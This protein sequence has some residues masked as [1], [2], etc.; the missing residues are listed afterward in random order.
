VSAFAFLAC[1]VGVIVNHWLSGWMAVGG[2]AGIGLFYLAIGLMSL[3]ERIPV[4]SAD[5]SSELNGI[6][7]SPEASLLMDTAS[8]SHSPTYPHRILK[9]RVEER[10]DRRVHP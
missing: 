5:D 4:Y 2:M 1:L 10:L 6:V 9:G 8:N 3:G 7:N